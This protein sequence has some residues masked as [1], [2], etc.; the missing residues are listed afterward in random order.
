MSDLSFQ[1]RAPLGLDLASGETVTIESWS[2]KGLH[3]P[4]AQ[5]E[6]PETAVLSIPFQGVDIRFDV[7]FDIDHDTQ[8]L[9][10]KGLTGR[11]RETLAVFYRS[12]LSGKMASTEEIITS[13][14]TPVDL[15]PMEETEEEKAEGTKGKTPRSLRAFFSVLL[16]LLVSTFVVWTLGKG[17]W[18][19]VGHVDIQNARIEAELIPHM[20]PEGG[21]AKRILV[22]AG[23]RVEEGQTLIE[24]STPETSAALSEV[25]S[26]IG[27]LEKRLAA[28]KAREAELQSVI[29]ER[30]GRLA[31][32]MDT[33]PVA[34]RTRLSEVL[35]DFDR[36]IS[37]EHGPLFE[38]HAAVQRELNL[39]EDELRRLRRQRGTLRAAADALH[40]I[41]AKTGHIREISALPGQ[42]LQRG[43]VAIE[44]ESA[45]KRQ[46][47]GW[48]DQR[49]ASAL[50]AGMPV[51]VTISRGGAPEIL[52]GRIEN[53]EAGINPELSPDFGMTVTVAF[54]NLS[55]DVVRT[56]LPHHMPV[57]LSA[58]RHWVTNLETRTQSLLAFAGD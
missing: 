34:E 12:I 32:A 44:L 23:E 14:D 22:S 10:F 16:Y 46:A 52:S 55:A 47:R 6:L 54:P 58:T 4:L 36:R 25:R 35:A 38:A 28:T 24:V 2:L 45:A 13:L 33:G 5:G 26:R 57:D 9:S 56:T 51:D 3:F 17:I 41:A 29:A 15:V 7:A 18:T 1:V 40:I 8:F 43:H 11:Q 42:Y 19:R 37:A 20:A 49:M 31:R 30:R 27:I 39:I 48:L 21:F 50:H 53:L